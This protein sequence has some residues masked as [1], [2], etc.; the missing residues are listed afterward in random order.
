M[1][2]KF[3]PNI[4]LNPNP[5]LMWAVIL[6][7]AGFGTVYMIVKTGDKKPEAAAQAAAP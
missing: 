6:V 4:E 1:A 7:F 2:A 5:I 3:D